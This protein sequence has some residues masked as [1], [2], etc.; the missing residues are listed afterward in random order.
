M[1]R[2]LVLDIGGSSIKYSIM[3]EKAEFLEKGNVTTPKEKLEEFVETIGC[4]YDKYKEEIS[5]IAISMP[6]IIDSEKGYAYTGGSL[7]YNNNKEIVKIL[8]KRCPVNITIENDGKC[9]ALAEVWKGTLKDCNDGIVIVL[10]T[11]L[12]EVL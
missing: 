11:V 10:G 4:L 7:L 9:A 3:T 2:Y 8:K 1:K 6:G 12:V 5:G